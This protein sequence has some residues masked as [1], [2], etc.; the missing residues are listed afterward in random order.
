M[1]GCYVSSWSTRVE[2]DLHALD[3]AAGNAGSAELLGCTR[4]RGLRL[5]RARILM[6]FSHALRY[7]KT[8]I[9]VL[10][11]QIIKRNTAGA[12]CKSVV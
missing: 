10:S 9:V 11:S 6:S 1:R 3:V 12:L 5:Q 7:D 2:R 4:P 8:I